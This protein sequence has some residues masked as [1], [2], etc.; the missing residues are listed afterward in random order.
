[1]SEHQDNDIARMHARMQAKQ[2][3]G[4]PYLD[5]G[6]Q[7]GCFGV[8]L[9]PLLDDAGDVRIVMGLVVGHV[10]PLMTK[11]KTDTLVFHEIA[12]VSVTELK[13]MVKSAAQPTE[14]AS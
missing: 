3:G 4:A 7:L 11:V 1:V 13:A 2:Q 14:P 9:L 10:S 5:L 12:K 8:Q 6:E